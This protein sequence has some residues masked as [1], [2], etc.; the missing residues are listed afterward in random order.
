MES[1]F[2]DWRPFANTTNRE[3]IAIR[4]KCELHI[5]G[6]DF[7]PFRTGR[8]IF[9]KVIGLCSDFFKI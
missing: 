3:G 6:S 8:S 4:R 5:F 2:F 7:D 9:P 1:G